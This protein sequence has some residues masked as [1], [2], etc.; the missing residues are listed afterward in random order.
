MTPRTQAAP[1]EGVAHF[2]SL[3]SQ[4]PPAANGAGEQDADR[5]FASDLNLDQ[6]VAAIAGDREE[7]D[8][9]TK[10]LFGHLHDADAVRYR[11]E[12]FQDLDDP[13]LFD[14]VQRFAERMQEV[15]AHLRQLEKMEYRY[16]R[17]G[18]LLDAAAIYCDAVAVAGGAPGLGAAQ[19][20]RPAGLPGV[21]CELRGL[22][23]L[24]RLGQRHQEPQGCPRADSLLH[25]HQ[26]RPGRGEPLSG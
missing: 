12:V 16:H 22:G 3:L 17:E 10:V 14:V 19:L 9:I 24:H 21:P 2:P 6:I 5:S 8:L 15:R 23:L 4:Q 13:A 25:P 18:W 11:Q 20:P 1:A 7:R 26:G